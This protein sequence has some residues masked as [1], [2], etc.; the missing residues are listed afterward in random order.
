M[1]THPRG[2]C[3]KRKRERERERRRKRGWSVKVS[4]GITSQRRR[5]YCCNP[6][7]FAA[8]AES[9]IPKR[10]SRWRR[11]RR[12]RPRCV[13]VSHTSAQGGCCFFYRR[14][15]TLRK[16][17]AIWHCRIT[18]VPLTPNDQQCCPLPRSRTVYL[19][20]PCTLLHI[21]SW[22]SS[23]GKTSYYK[24]DVVLNCCFFFLSFL[25][26][27]KHLDM[28]HTQENDK[29][30]EEEE[31]RKCC[32]KWNF[33]R[34]ELFRGYNG[35]TLGTLRRFQLT[36]VGEREKERFLYTY[37]WESSSALSLSLSLSLSLKAGRARQENF[38]K[39][40][41]SRTSL[42]MWLFWSRVRTVRNILVS[43]ISKN[44]IL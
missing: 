5:L 40:P 38:N 18:Y 9:D 13:V 23:K 24:T 20:L 39:S 17:T 2:S 42:C 4:G 26:W 34:R 29:A 36:K 16:Q 8:V 7:S 19:W 30:E 33:G 35:P 28:T 32:R 6:G 43:K 15:K 1:W 44:L 41:S 11:R 22:S 12:R 21:I 37:S 14:H 31:K 3:W 27:G 10:L 25:S